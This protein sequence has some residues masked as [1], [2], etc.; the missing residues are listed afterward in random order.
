MLEIVLVEE[1]GEEQEMPRRKRRVSPFYGAILPNG[2][3]AGRR[4]DK[5]LGNTPST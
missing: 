5:R 3:P 2:L 4:P 1:N